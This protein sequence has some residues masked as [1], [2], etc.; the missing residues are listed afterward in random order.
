MWSASSARRKLSA[1]LDRA[2]KDGPQRIE[3]RKRGFVVLTATDYETLTGR[4]V[5]DL[6]RTKPTMSLGEF[7]LNGPSFEGIEFPRDRSLPREL[8][9][10]R[11]GED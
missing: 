6:G 2:G 10:G 4:R 3:R 1:L 7:L 8:D 11:S 9:L 5:A